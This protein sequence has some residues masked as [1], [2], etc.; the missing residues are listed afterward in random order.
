MLPQL[1]K[2]T[3]ET[4]TNNQDTAFMLDGKELMKQFFG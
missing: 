4:F 3:Y 2:Q 1:Q